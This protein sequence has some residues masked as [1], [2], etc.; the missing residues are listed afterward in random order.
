LLHDGGLVKTRQFSSPRYV[1]DPINA[2]RIYN[3]KEVDE[4]VFLDITAT[5]EGRA[6]DF[7]LVAA[8]ASECF[9][10]FCVGGG[11]RQLGQI[12]SLLRLGVEKVALNAI[13]AESP[14]FVEA[15]A[16]RFGSQ[17]IVVSID[18]KRSLLGSYGVRTR[19]GTKSV[20]VHPV[21]YARRAEELGA[22]E[23]LLTS[24]DRD[25]TMKGYD[26]ELTGAV[27]SAV[28]VPVIACGGAGSIG[29]LASVTQNAG[30]SAAAAGSLFVYHGKHH[31]VLINFP[32]RAE[33]DAVMLQ[34]RPVRIPPAVLHQ[35]TNS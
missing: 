18:V 12:E 4:L 29:D 26:L 16:R 15:A 27:A 34:T 9:M 17:S 33:L 8:I 30:A 32:A 22:G 23:I 6:P 21:A 3:E 24:I 19:G 10:P 13:A 20:G 25:G 5:K 31:A 28:T 2:V 7:E 35:T 14:E 11:I 1:G